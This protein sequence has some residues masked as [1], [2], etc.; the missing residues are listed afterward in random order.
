MERRLLEFYKDMIQARYSSML[1]GRLGKVE[2]N[3][4]GG[5]GGGGGDH[6]KFE[7]VEGDDDDEVK[8]E[9]GDE[10]EGDVDEDPPPPTEPCVKVEITSYIDAIRK[11]GD[12]NGD[13]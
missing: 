9:E 6:N 12:E 5:G 13:R 11:G 4:T 10:E 2:A 8:W 3:D 7:K 1:R